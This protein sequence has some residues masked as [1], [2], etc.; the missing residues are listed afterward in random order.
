MSPITLE[1]KA[2]ETRTFIV[3]FS[4]KLDGEHWP[5]G[6]R[7]D[8]LPTSDGYETLT[9]TPTV[10]ELYTAALTISSVSINTADRTFPGIVYPANRAVQFTVAGGTAREEYT[11]R[12]SVP[13]DGSPQQT[14]IKDARLRVS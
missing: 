6:P 14:L 5:V 8:W 11:L 3:D 13:T 2:G 7:I 10:T 1:K 12:I 9:G 4:D